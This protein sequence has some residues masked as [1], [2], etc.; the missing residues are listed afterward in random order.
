MLVAILL[1]LLAV[2]EVGDG[3]DALFKVCN[4]ALALLVWNFHLVRLGL[5]QECHDA[6][7]RKKTS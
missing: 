6:S 2:D 1:F 7:H 5:G 4:Q 3:E